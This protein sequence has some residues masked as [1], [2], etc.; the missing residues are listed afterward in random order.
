MIIICFL[1]GSSAYCGC[2]SVH[3]SLTY[4]VL[5]IKKYKRIINGALTYSNTGETWENNAIRRSQRIH[6]LS[7]QLI[8]EDRQRFHIFLLIILVLEPLG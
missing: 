7:V 8:L 1:I 2:V 4:R 6:T 5:K 3:V